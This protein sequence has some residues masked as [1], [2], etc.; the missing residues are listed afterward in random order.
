MAIQ[1]GLTQ[2][3]RTGARLIASAWVSATRPP[4]LA[5]YASV[6]GSDMAAR[7]DAIDTNAPSEARSG[8]S[9]ALA[10]RNAAVR[11]TSSTRRHSAMV[12]WRIGLRIM[13][14][15]LDTMP[16]SCPKR[17]I[18]SATARFGRRLVA[19]VAFD[20]P[21]AARLLAEGAREVGSGD[22]DRA[23]QPAVIEQ[24]P[25]RRAPDA[26]RCAGDER[27]LFHRA[28]GQSSGPCAFFQ[29]SM[30]PV[31]VAGAVEPRVLRGLHRHGGALAEGAVEQQPLAVRRSSA[32]S[33][34]PGAMLARRSG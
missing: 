21:D 4:L 11:L 17:S 19:D 16:S 32:C 13:M 14:P 5:E 1:P 3:T 22:V 28:C 30:P 12:S 9:P 10:S 29:A 33:M 2:L 34:P 24:L 7:V 18:V 6:F 27:D 26:V 8:F 25:C 20:D 15:A 31:Q 23:D